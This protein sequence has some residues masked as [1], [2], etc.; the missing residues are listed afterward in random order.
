MK[1]VV[2]KMLLDHLVGVMLAFV[3]SPAVVIRKAFYRR[4]LPVHLIRSSR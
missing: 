4:Y 3:E 2:G 1:R